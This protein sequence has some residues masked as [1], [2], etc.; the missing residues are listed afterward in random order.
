MSGT[1][2]LG[3]HI[4]AALAGVLVARGHAADF[5]DAA[6]ART[7]SRA[8]ETRADAMADDRDDLWR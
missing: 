4:A 7:M 6:A 3:L 5:Y 2:W 8:R 1:W